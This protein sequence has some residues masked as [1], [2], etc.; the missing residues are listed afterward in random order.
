MIR[1]RVIRIINLMNEPSLS[2]CFVCRPPQVSVLT[3]L[4]K[5]LMDWARAGRKDHEENGH[6]L[7]SHN[8]KGSWNRRAIGTH[9]LLVE[10]SRPIRLKLVGNLASLRLEKSV[11]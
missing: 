4:K 11:A 10:M 5:R 1:H 6:Y 2:V 8:Q 7:L 9:T 3:L